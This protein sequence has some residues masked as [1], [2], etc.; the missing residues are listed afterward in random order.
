[1][2]KVEEIRQDMKKREQQFMSYMKRIQSAPSQNKQKAAVSD[3]FAWTFCEPR[4]LIVSYISMLALSN[5]KGRLEHLEKSRPQSNS[6]LSPLV[7]NPDLRFALENIRPPTTVRRK[8]IP[9]EEQCLNLKR[10]LLEQVADRFSADFVITHY[11]Q[12][13]AL[14]EEDTTNDFIGC[15]GEAGALTRNFSRRWAETLAEIAFRTTLKVKSIKCV[16][17]T[18]REDPAASPAPKKCLVELS[19]AHCVIDKGQKNCSRSDAVGKCIVHETCEECLIE[20]QRRTVLIEAANVYT[21]PS[22]FDSSFNGI[23]LEG[24]WLNIFS[25]LILENPNGFEAAQLCE[26]LF[27]LM[28]LGMRIAPLSAADFRPD[29]VA[30]N[31]ETLQRWNRDEKTGM[32]KIKISIF[33][34][35]PDAFY[36]IAWDLCN[37]TANWF[38]EINDFDRW[39]FGNKA[40]IDRAKARFWREIV[41]DQ[42]FPIAENQ[43]DIIEFDLPLLAF[44][45]LK[46]FAFCCE[47]EVY[48]AVKIHFFVDRGGSKKDFWGQ[49]TKD[50]ILEISG[51]RLFS[52]VRDAL[53]IIIFHAYHA[54]VVDEKHEQNGEGKVSAGADLVSHAGR[55]KRF[56]PQKRALPDGQ[57]SHWKEDPVRSAL[58]ASGRFG[59]I[60]DDETLVSAFWRRLRGKGCGANEKKGESETESRDTGL[61]HV[62]TK[63]DLYS[64]IEN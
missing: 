42:T 10:R 28:T 64:I 49:I 43:Q 45:G 33:W 3:W 7:Q 39:Q 15:F 6:A 14:Q 18:E 54:I 17:K 27:Y 40:Q 8:D 1:M 9:S 13:L 32:E 12:L 47:G 20:V 57:S 35:V 34:Q 46:S 62:Y 48:P 51:Q 38:D 58:A 26:I 21:I 4:N 56:R 53:E 50:G 31:N 23:P 25:K 5:E 24:G 60:E 2:S 16:L 29:H 55:K 59:K 52:W 61:H 22:L 37:K 30:A 41:D 19:C 63:N 36:H 44:C 11:T